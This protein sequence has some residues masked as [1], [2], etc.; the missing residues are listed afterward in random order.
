M[1]PFEKALKTVLDSARRLGSERVDITRAVNRILAEDVKS[2]IDMPPFDKATRDGYACRRKDLANELTIIETI[3]AGTSP[4]RAIEPNQCSKIMTG[5]AVPQGADC[6]IMVEFTRAP[7][8]GA[9]FTKNPTA[10]TVRFI[11]ENT[12]DHIC[13]KGEDVRAGEV[14]LHKG[15]RIR[16]QHIAVLASVGCTQPV[17]SKRPRVAVFATGDELVQ[18]ASRPGPSQ[19][20]NSNVFQLVAQIESMG[21]VAKNY[22]IAKDT[23]DAIDKM[24]KEAVDESD[25]V[26]VSGGVSVGDFDLVPG[27]FK[28][29]NI[30]LLFEKVAVKPGKP[31]VFGVSEKVYCFGLPGNPVSTFVQFEL[32]VKPFLCK[33]MGH[34]YKHP[35]SQIPLGESLRRKNTERQSWIPVVITDAGTLKPVEYHG[36]AHIN[37]LCIADGLVSIGVGVAEIEKGTIVPVRLI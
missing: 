5:A 30:D 18:P 15:N 19:I 17:V 4:Q 22:G 3:Q 32:L 1:L 9:G 33:L 2:D 25:V 24:F 16:P 6:V 21:A 14:V 20:R 31:T 37:A 35:V 10:N 29:N 36:S 11:G 23:D 12:P 26:I 34:D 8:A 27:V 13:L 7:A 28:R